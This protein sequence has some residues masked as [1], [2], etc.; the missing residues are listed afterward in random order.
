MPDTVTAENGVVFERP[1]LLK[2]LPSSTGISQVTDNNEVWPLF[3]ATQRADSNFSPCEAAR[4]PLS[5]DLESLYTRY[6]GNTLTTQIGWS[7]KYT[8]WALDN[9]QGN[10][11]VVNLSNGSKWST[12]NTAYQ[13]CLVHP[14]ATVSSVTLTSTALDSST[15]AAKAEKGEGVPLT[16]TVKDSAGKPVSNV[17]FTLKRGDASPRN[18]GATLSGNVAAMDDLTVQPS[19]GS[20]VTLTDSGS[21]ISGVTGAD[22][23]ASFTLKQDNTPGYKTPMTVMLTDSPTLTATLDVI[24]TVVTSP[25][26]TTA[27]FWGHMPDTTA[28][29]GKTLHRP[30]LESELPSAATAVATADVNNET[31]GLAHTMDSYQWDISQQCGLLDFAPDYADLQALHVNFNAL[32]WP[33]LPDTPYLSKERDRSG[34]YYCGIIEETGAEDCSIQATSTPGFATCVR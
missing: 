21:S 28:V 29:N 3:N 8:W 14:R 27:H 34:N 16:V 1:K 25:N 26:V 13:G 9:W 18:T 11:Q 24:F 7:T 10:A 12:V 31:W 6:P 4:R 5:D 15:Q 23:T 20:I 19:S 2:E 17:A 32:G 30:Q 33:S 22:G